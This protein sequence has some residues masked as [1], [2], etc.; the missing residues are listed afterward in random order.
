MRAEF[1]GLTHLCHRRFG[2]SQEAWTMVLSG[3]WRVSITAAKGLVGAPDVIE[4]T[5]EGKDWTFPLEGVANVVKDKEV[6]GA[7]ILVQ[8]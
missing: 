2:I 6:V 5:F 3:D 1:A 7:H 8:V 4:L